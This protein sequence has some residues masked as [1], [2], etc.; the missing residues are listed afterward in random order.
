MSVDKKVTK[1]IEKYEQQITYVVGA[2][3]AIGWLTIGVLQILD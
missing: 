1:F 3:I 2:I